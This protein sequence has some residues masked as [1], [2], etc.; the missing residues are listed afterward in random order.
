MQGGVGAVRARARCAA[1]AVG[2]LTL[3]GGRRQRRQQGTLQLQCSQLCL[4]G[5]CS[6]PPPSTSEGE[7]R[8]VVGQFARMRGAPRRWSGA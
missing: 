6:G 7:C 3:P 4:G 1:Q 5:L 2:G 8:V